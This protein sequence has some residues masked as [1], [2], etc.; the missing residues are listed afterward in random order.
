[1]FNHF[2][3]TIKTRPA[4]WMFNFYHESERDMN[5]ILGRRT[6]CRTDVQV[7]VRANNEQKFAIFSKWFQRS[8]YQ[9]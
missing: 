8:T 9:T 5:A 6:F 4:K 2:Q 7:Y 3:R 1:M